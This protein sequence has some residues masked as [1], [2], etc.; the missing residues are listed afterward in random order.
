MSLFLPSMHVGA[1]AYFCFFA[2]T[3][4]QVVGYPASP[5]GAVDP[6]TMASNHPNLNRSSSISSE[7]PY[8]KRASVQASN[9]ADAS[10]GLFFVLPKE[11]GV[12]SFQISGRVIMGLRHFEMF[13]KDKTKQK[14]AMVTCNDVIFI[15]VPKVCMR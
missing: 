10:K 8:G 4:S 1:R 11:M 5:E 2:T 7:N 14:V 15:C 13:S 3:C 6:N 12:F 9:V